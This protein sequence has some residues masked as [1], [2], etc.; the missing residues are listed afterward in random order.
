MKCLRVKPTF[1]P[2]IKGAVHNLCR[3]GFP[4]SK[5]WQS[6]GMLWRGKGSWEFLSDSTRA[7]NV[8]GWGNVLNFIHVRYGCT[9]YNHGFVNSLDEP[10]AQLNKM[11]CM[12]VQEAKFWS[13]F[14]HFNAQ[15]L[16]ILPLR[17]SNIL[18]RIIIYDYKELLHY[19]CRPFLEIRVAFK[20]DCLKLD[21][22]ARKGRAVR[23]SWTA[24]TE[25][26]KTTAHTWAEKSEL[27]LYGCE[28]TDS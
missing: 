22:L 17:K 4:Q 23:V 16:N 20:L 26:T 15:L 24:E 21:K 13:F 12:R 8:N 2:Q 1:A 19:L 7:E 6:M 18:I 5:Q 25:L 11:Y 3:Y 28:P 27:C 14:T 10:S 9:G